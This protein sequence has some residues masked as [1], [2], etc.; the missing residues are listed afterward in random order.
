[1]SRSEAHQYRDRDRFNT[2]MDA[3]DALNPFAVLDDTDSEGEEQE[4]GGDEGSGAQGG[5]ES[6]DCGSPSN[7][8]NEGG[9][10]AF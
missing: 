7:D 3:Y 5:S 2:L 8:S 4:E 10:S 6:E 1:M 9:D